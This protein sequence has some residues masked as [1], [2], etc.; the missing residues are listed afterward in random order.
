MRGEV[1]ITLQGTNIM[2]KNIPYS[3]THFRVED[4]IFIC[5]GGI[6]V[7]FLEGTL[8]Q[9]MALPIVDLV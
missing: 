2:N 6:L 4:A 3:K 5:Q 9:Y 7:R 8:V 1:G